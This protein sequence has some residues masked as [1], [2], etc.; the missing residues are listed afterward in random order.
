[1]SHSH[2]T[3]PEKHGANASAYAPQVAVREGNRLLCPCCGEVLMIL[4]EEPA[5]ESQ[6]KKFWPPKMAPPKR[7][8][9]PQSATLNEIIRRQEAQEEAAFQAAMTKDVPSKDPPVEAFDPDRPHYRADSIV[10]EIDPEINAYEFPEID[11]PLVPSGLTP[12][13]SRSDSGEYREPR[14]R[15]AV[16]RYEERKRYRL[17]QPL[18]EPLTYEAA[19]LYAWMFYRMKKLN[20]QLIEEI[21]AK[22]AEID[23][24]EEE[25]NAPVKEASSEEQPPSET[26]PQV[27]SRVE[28]KKIITPTRRKRVLRAIEKRVHGD[29]RMASNNETRQVETAHERG[30]P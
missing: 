23:A 24:L 5:N 10:V 21:T 26:Q 25:L 18:R 29:V 16:T 22:Q 20:L 12:K 3:Q 4:Q 30:P 15:D 13:R 17:R 19:R 27:V 6:P 9:R 7:T 1:M 28:T 11:P 14:E 2:A 8:P